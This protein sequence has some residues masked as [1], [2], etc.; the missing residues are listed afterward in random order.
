MSQADPA[1]R[2]ADRKASAPMRLAV[3]AGFL[4]L[5]GLT[6]QSRAAEML[7]GTYALPDGQPKVSAT[8][9]VLPGSGLRRTLDVAMTPIGST[10]PVTRYET[11]LSKQLHIIAVSADLRDFV[12]E[13]GDT[14]AADG[15]FRVPMTFPHTGSWYVYADG[16]PDGLGQQVMRFN[17]VLGKPSAA[18][19]LLQD[20]KATGLTATDGGYAARFDDFGLKAGQEA[21]LSLHL[22]HGGKP[23][24]DITPFLGVA[25]H[26]VFIDAADLSYVHV[27]A[28]PAEAPAVGGTGT[29]MQHDSASMKDMP[30]MEGMG[31]PL[32][33][34]AHVP[35]S[36][37]LHV[38]APKAGTYVLWMQFNGGGKVRTV[39]FVV[40]VS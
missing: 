35:P 34:G 7:I 29:P 14:P 31:P 33:A 26:A 25:A 23:A 20:L 38:R 32:A 1:F 9:V 8:L 11:E 22:L 19:A 17:A 4:L 30:S 2:P 10:A 13:H 39:R 24:A 37:A 3:L 36:L 16:V 18:P 15:H 12:H 5:G 6:S 21:Q 27:H 28:A 40:P